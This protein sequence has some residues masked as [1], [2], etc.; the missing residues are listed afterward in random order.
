MKNGDSQ[1]RYELAVLKHHKSRTA[2]LLF[3]T[4]QLISEWLMIMTNGKD[5]D[6]EY[7]SDDLHLFELIRWMYGLINY[8]LVLK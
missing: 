1:A 6:K 3:D 7:I 2:Q 8:P 5:H 4:P